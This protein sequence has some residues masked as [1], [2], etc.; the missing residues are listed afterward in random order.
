MR[1][2]DVLAKEGK[3]RKRKSHS[4]NGMREGSREMGQGQGRAGFIHV[5]FL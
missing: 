4:G 2:R 5:L 1:V 3:L